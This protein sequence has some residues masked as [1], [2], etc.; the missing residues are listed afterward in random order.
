MA[1]FELYLRLQRISCKQW[2]AEP[3]D[4]VLCERYWIE[5]SLLNPIR[6][7]LVADFLKGSVRQHGMFTSWIAK[8]LEVKIYEVYNF[9]ILEKILERILSQERRVLNGSA[10]EYIWKIW[11]IIFLSTM[12][13]FS[14]SLLFVEIYVYIICILIV[15]FILK[16]QQM[17]EKLNILKDYCR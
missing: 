8:T 9:V 2:V 10:K 7:L 14:I 5:L 15:K 6:K 11:R 12:S 17:K 16:F 1:K 13:W 3:K 4:E